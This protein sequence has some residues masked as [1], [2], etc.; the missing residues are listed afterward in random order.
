MFFSLIGF[1]IPPH[2]RLP[3]RFEKPAAYPNRRFVCP[4]R[5]FSRFRRIR[6]RF[7]H[8]PSSIVFRP[9]ADVNPVIWSN[10]V[11]YQF[12]GFLAQREEI[13]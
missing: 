11:F 3:S 13:L 1:R 6:F 7:G 9:P 5:R 2:I 10:F 4:L 12:I 8:I